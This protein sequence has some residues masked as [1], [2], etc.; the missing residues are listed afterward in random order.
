MKLNYS[1]VSFGGAL[2]DSNDKSAAWFMCG[3]VMIA[4]QRI[5]DERGHGGVLLESDVSKQEIV[6][7]SSRIW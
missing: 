1:E 4:G 5:R 3:L 6:E 2:G 7:V